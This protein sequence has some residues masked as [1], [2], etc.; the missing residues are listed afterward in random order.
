M[1]LPFP[2][3]QQSNLR[4]KSAEMFDFLNNWMD[5]DKTDFK[6]LQVIEFATRL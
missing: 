3:I 1:C 2:P 6:N 5:S 4:T